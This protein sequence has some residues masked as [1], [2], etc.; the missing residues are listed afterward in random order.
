MARNRAAARSTS[1]G[2]GVSLTNRRTSLVAMKTRRRRMLRQDVEHLLAVG[3]AAAGLDH[4]AEHDL[5]PG[6]VQARVEV[7]A[8]AL[9]RA[10]QSSSR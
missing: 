10:D 2:G 5:L 4:V 9:P 3:L 6:V 8:A 1:A 7:E